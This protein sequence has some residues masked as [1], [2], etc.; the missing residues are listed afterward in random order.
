MILAILGLGLLACGGNGSQENDTSASENQDGVITI[1]TE[2]GNVTID[3]NELEAA[4]DEFKAS[5]D[6]QA[7][8]EVMNFRELKAVLPDRLLRMDRTEHTGETTGAFGMKFSTAEATYE[9]G[10]RRLEIVIMDAAK[11]GVAQLGAALWTQVEIDRESDDG[12]E[13]TITIDGHRGYEKFDTRSGDAELAIFYK[14]RY[15]I[16]LDGRQLDMDDLRN[17]LDDLDL[18]ELQ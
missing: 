17:A 10:D 9:D 14:D 4:M 2:D 15:L 5:M 8:V 18:N 12:Y 16:T 13:R 1:E 6:D 3:A 11:M 7:D